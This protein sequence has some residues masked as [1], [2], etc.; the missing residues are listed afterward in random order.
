MAPEKSQGGA[1]LLGNKQER[2][3]A[4]CEML[5]MQLIKNL[6]LYISLPTNVLQ[7]LV[8]YF[9]GPMCIFSET[10]N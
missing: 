6:H 4:Q 10:E 8:F 1:Q 9:D 7:A 5:S 2:E 3:E